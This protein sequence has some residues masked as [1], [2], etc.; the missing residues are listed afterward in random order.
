ME[1]YSAS[2][3]VVVSAAATLRLRY[4]NP[5]FTTKKSF[6]PLSIS[7]DSQSRILTADDDNYCFHIVDQDGHFLRY[8]DNCSV[9]LFVAELSTGKVKKIHYYK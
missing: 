6:K 1:D 4:T 9:K 5:P 8:I 3:V 2:A 7:T